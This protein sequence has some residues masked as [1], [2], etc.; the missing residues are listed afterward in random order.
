M[1][2][3]GRRYSRDINPAGTAGLRMAGTPVRMMGMFM[4]MTHFALRQAA[5]ARHR[6]AVRAVYGRGPL[7]D[8]MMEQ[9]ERYVR[10]FY[11]Y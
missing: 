3:R 7:A 1:P 9:H 4:P 10:A 5:M 2:K 6:A 11:G 8:R